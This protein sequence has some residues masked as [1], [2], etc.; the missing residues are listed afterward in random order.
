[1][2]AKLALLLVGWLA[3]HHSGFAQTAPTPVLRP[4]WTE[5][6]SGKPATPPP[7]GLRPV[8]GGGLLKEI[9]KWAPY[10]ALDSQRK[11]ARRQADEMAAAK[12][13]QGHKEVIVSLWQR[14]GELNGE[15]ITPVEG[16][17][18]VIAGAGVTFEDALDQALRPQMWQAGSRVVEQIRYRAGEPMTG[19]L[20]GLRE[21]SAAVVRGRAEIDRASA[22]EFSSAQAEQAAAERNAAAARNEQERQRAQAASNEVKKKRASIAQ[23]QRDR[24]QHRREMDATKDRMLNGTASDDDRRRYTDEWEKFLRASATG[25]CAGGA[26][27]EGC[28]PCPVCR[29]GFTPETLVRERDWLAPRL[30]NANVR[31][32]ALEKQ[33]K[34]EAIKREVVHGGRYNR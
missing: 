33:F 2:N 23:E 31:M 22:R 3:V 1:M 28:T 6:V 30:K 9:N 29:V 12:I 18:A 25:K 34:R 7:A 24:E 19:Q 10:W 27:G 4:W 20:V 16:M 17:G 11:A 21:Y 8:V 26:A 5:M 14:G 13:G 32:A 15:T